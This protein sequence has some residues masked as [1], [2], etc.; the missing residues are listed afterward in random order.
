MIRKNKYSRKIK[1]FKKN[2][3]TFIKKHK[4]LSFLV[5]FLLL[6]LFSIKIAYNHYINNPKN[7]IKTVYFD[8]NVINNPN[9]SG[10]MNSTKNTLSWKNIIKNKFTN[11][12]TEK[13]II[14]GTYK[15]IKKI[16]IKN[17][18]DNSVY[19]SFSFSKP[20]LQVIWSW[21]DFLIYNP[22]NI[23]PFQSKYL[24][25]LKFLTWEKVYLPKYLLWLKNLNG[26][27]WKNSLDKL[28]TYIKYIHQQMPNS[29]IYYLAW[30]EYLKVFYNNK[31][32][33]FSLSKDIKLQFKQ[34]NLL[35]IKLPDKL[36]NSKEIDLWSLKEWV[37][38]DNH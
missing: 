18:W 7:I 23:Y 1:H 27:F 4:W 10:L 12:K 35:K 30:W 31:A 32:Y 17:M 29:K 16:D 36:K 20:L 25:G 11:Y 3:S 6:A 34:L 2:I 5:V 15:Y 28:L 14:K 22:K 26:I 38:L 13:T 21:T 8:K 33:L 37:F 19:V 24:S 9:F